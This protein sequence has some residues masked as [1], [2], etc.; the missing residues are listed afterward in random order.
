MHRIH[1][2]VNIVWYGNPVPVMHAFQ[3]MEHTKLQIKQ[4][5]VCAIG[6]KCNWKFN[7]NSLCSENFASNCSWAEIM[8][9]HSFFCLF[10]KERNLTFQQ[11]MQSLWW[12]SFDFW[13][14][15]VIYKVTNPINCYLMLKYIACKT[16]HNYN[17]DVFFV[18]EWGASNYAFRKCSISIRKLW[19][20][21]ITKH[22][23]QIFLSKSFLSNMQ[24]RG[25]VCLYTLASSYFW[26]ILFCAA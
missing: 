24:S 16:V 3:K 26:C 9:F 14:S 25:Y 7:L 12:K 6:E 17:A 1:F 2:I 20:H 19:W 15:F 23:L 5:K 10:S 18:R 22:S 13:F 4:I 21:Q 11:T 8:V